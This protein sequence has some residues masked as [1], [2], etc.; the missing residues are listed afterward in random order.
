MPTLPNGLAINLPAGTPTEAP[1]PDQVGALPLT[2]GWV[3]FTHLEHPEELAFPITQMIAMQQLIGGGR[4]VQSLGPQPDPWKWSGNLFDNTALSRAND[5]SIM[6]KDG[7]TRNLVWGPYSFNVIVSKF[8]PTHLQQ[9][10]IKYDIEVTYVSDAPGATNSIP[11]PSVDQLTLT[12]YQQANDRAKALSNIDTSANGPTT[13]LPTLVSI[14]N[15]LTAL[16]PIANAAFPAIQPIS[17]AINTL[18]ATVSAYVLPLQSLTPNPTI[19]Q[20]IMLGFGVLNNLRIVNNNLSS[21]TGTTSVFS[22]GLSAYHLAAQ[23][24]GDASQY[25]LIMQVNKLASPFIPAGGQQKIIIPPATST[26]TIQ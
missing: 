15:S 7:K 2:I 21:G 10:W 16:G 19:A 11:S 17:A 5:L 20:Q 1:T 4:S 14:G 13:W 18:A 25:G 9:F 12:L 24:Y 8:I 6:A 3:T 23:Y 26:N 22:P